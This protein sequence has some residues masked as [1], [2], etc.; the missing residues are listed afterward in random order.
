MPDLIVE[1]P[2]FEF[3]NVQGV[4]FPEDVALFPGDFAKD[5]DGEAGAGK[6]MPHDDVF[7]DTEDAAQGADFVLVQAVQGF[8]DPAGVSFGFHQ[9]CADV[10]MAFDDLGFFTDSLAAFDKVGVQGALGE[11]IGIRKLEPR[12]FPFL[13]GDKQVADDFP[14][15]FRV[16]VAG[17]GGKELVFAVDYVEVPGPQALQ[18]RLYDAGLV[19]PHEPGIHV[20]QVDLGG[21]EGF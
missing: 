9:G 5:A 20:H 13:D 19:L 18:V 14:F 17:E 2:F 4:G 21:V 11:E 12:Y 7:V 16:L 10:M 3:P 8:D 6:G 15:G 1:A